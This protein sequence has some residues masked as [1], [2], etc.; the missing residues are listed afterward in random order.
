MCDP[1]V[2]SPDAVFK[3]L[4]VKGSDIWEVQNEVVRCCLEDSSAV[5]V[6]HNVQQKSNKLYD[7]FLLAKP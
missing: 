1:L 6:P 3:K 4:S 2:L 7:I 5:I